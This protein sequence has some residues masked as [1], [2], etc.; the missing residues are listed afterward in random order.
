MDLISGAS[1]LGFDELV[2]S[3]GGDPVA[4]LETNGLS[5]ADC[6]RA[7]AYVPLRL[8]VQAVERAAVATHTPDFERRL[9]DRQGI[10]ILGAVGLA[11]RTS[12][13]F[14]KALGIFERYTAAYSP[15][16]AVPLVSGPEPGTT[17]MRWLTT[18]PDM[19]PH[20]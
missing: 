8:A 5:V 7:E 13:T 9:A 10:E 4:L 12:T 1:L 15:G 2:R 14:G 20:P 16:I 11:A 19:A 18:L 17:F 6:G 3:R